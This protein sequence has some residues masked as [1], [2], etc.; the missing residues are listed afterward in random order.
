M[1]FIQEFVRPQLVRVLNLEISVPR[2]EM[3]LQFHLACNIFRQYRNIP[4]IR[5][6]AAPRLT[7]IFGKRLALVNYCPRAILS[8][9][10]GR[11]RGG[12][13]R[14]LL[15][16]APPADDVFAVM[17]V[18]NSMVRKILPKV[19]TRWLSRVRNFVLRC[20]PR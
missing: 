7:H 8:L 9:R 19:A 3:T 12:W 14:A 10:F 16:I 15:L 18:R 2:I 11:S 17:P 6:G 1:K 13:F 4:G 5:T 20:H